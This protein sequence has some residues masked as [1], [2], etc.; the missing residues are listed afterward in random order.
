MKRGWGGSGRPY[1]CSLGL[2]RTILLRF[3]IY[4]I[5][6]FQNV[7]LSSR[8]SKSHP[9]KGR[10]YIFLFASR[11]RPAAHIYE[12]SHSIP[13][14]KGRAKIL[15]FSLRLLSIITENMESGFKR[16]KIVSS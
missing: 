9:V 2:S 8:K 11:G 5:L 3:L 16:L 4:P 15:F 1:L 14:L 7:A 13:P 12:H 10:L 6:D